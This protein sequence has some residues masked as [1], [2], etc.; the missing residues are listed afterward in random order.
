MP[1]T[2]ALTSRQ[3]L[4]LRAFTAVAIFE[5][6]TWVGLLT[7]MYFKYLATDTTEVGV[8]IFGP[9]HGAAFVAYLLLAV[10]AWRVLRWS[11]GTLVTALVCSVPPLFTVVFEVWAARTGR[12]VP[13][14][15]PA[16][17]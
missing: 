8:K 3:R 16:L 12:L 2:D 15:R 13:E 10:I 17:V 6:F 4:T 1:A 14:Q 11:F 9:I 7:G 5:A